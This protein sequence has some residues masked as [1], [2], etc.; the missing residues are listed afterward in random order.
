M[1]TYVKIKPDY[2][3]SSTEWREGWERYSGVRLVDY[4]ARLKLYTLFYKDHPLT[5]LDGTVSPIEVRDVQY[6]TK[7]LIYAHNGD[8]YNIM[9]VLKKFKKTIYEIMENFEESLE[10]ETIPFKTPSEYFRIPKLVDSRP[11]EG[12]FNLRLNEYAY[13]EIFDKYLIII[14]SY[15]R[16]IEIQLDIGEFESVETD[17]STEDFESHLYQ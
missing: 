2:R 13:K 15:D 10:D 12:A 4:I 5:L 9:R 16:L 6:Q 14:K 7:L 17:I 8:L 1:T 3:F 11:D